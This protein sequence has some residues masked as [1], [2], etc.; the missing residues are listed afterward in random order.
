MEVYKSLLSK[1]EIV[2]VVERMQS[3]KYRPLSSDFIDRA[4][5]EKG[6]WINLN[7]VHL[8]SDQPSEESGRVS[9]AMTH[10]SEGSFLSHEDFDGSNITFTADQ[11]EQNWK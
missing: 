10:Y 6:V 4:I 9:K 2:G 3:D 7:K 11:I 1:P 5:H 8:S